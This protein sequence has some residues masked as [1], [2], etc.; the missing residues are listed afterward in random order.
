MKPFFPDARQP[1]LVVGGPYSNLEAAQALISEA[2]RLNVPAG[3][4]LC[5]GNLVACCAS[6]QETV[7]L[8]RDWGI[9]VVMGNCEESFGNDADDCGCGFEEGAVCDR[10][11]A[12]WYNYSKPRLSSI[13]KQ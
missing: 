9:A 6:P 13:H 12:S 11:S 5:T 3:N 8:I 10:L 2:D 4:V 7:G 1:L